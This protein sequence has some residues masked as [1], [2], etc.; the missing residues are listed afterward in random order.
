MYYI[1]VE[2]LTNDK[3]KALHDDLQKQF[4]KRVVEQRL[5]GKTTGFCIT[6]QNELNDIL[7]KYPLARCTVE[8]VDPKK[9]KN[10]PDFKRDEELGI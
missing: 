6:K 1:N 3:I 10:A 9:I 2:N 5:G 7:L 4:P 8:P